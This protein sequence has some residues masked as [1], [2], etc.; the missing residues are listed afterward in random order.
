[1]NTIITAALIGTSVITTIWAIA[2]GLYSLEY[3]PK[4]KRILPSV[5]IITGVLIT[6]IRPEESIYVRTGILIAEAGLLLAFVQ[7]ARANPHEK[8]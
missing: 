5:F 7:A 6:C 1:M 4:S 8:K 2:G 3:L